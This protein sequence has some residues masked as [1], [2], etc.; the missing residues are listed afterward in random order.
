[1]L[2]CKKCGGK[3]LTIKCGKNNKQKTNNNYKNKNYKNNNYSNKRNNSKTYCI[4][5]SNLPS[6]ISASELNNLIKPWAKIGNINFGKSLIKVAYIDF[7][8]LDEAEYFVKALNKTPFDKLIIDV[9]IYKK[10]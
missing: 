1:M 8:N 5:I 9:E 7:Y 4:K 10:N 6:D 2:I 3:H